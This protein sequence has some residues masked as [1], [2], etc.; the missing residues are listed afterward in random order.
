MTQH[1][2]DLVKR[3]RDAHENMGTGS[4]DD[5]KAAAD[6]I[7]RLQAEVARLGSFL[8]PIGMIVNV[9]EGKNFDAEKIAE[10]VAKA[11]RGE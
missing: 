8:H 10:L 1:D 3:L 7:E 4:R 2:N 6:E 9:K 5:L 11:V